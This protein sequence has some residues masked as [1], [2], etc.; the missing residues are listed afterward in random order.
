MINNTG[1]QQ[2]C[3]HYEAQGLQEGDTGHRGGG[4]GGRG[5]GALDQ[6]G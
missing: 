5:R 6:G 4:R 2:R 3:R 1:D